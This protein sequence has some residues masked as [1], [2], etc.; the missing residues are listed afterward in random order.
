MKERFL[1]CH[2]S[3]TQSEG[4]FDFFEPNTHET[5]FFGVHCG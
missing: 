1:S 2:G 4:R 5:L 3:V